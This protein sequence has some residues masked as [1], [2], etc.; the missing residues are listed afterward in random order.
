MTN[1][2]PTN[3]TRR[4]DALIED[5]IRRGATR[6]DLLKMLISSGVALGAGGSLLMKAGQAVA[7]TPKTGGHMKAAGWSSS[8]AD[9]LDP[10]KA[11]LSTDYTR[12]CALYNR[13]TFL[14]EAGEVD[15]ELAESIESSDAKTWQVKLRSGISFHDGKP[16]T[17]ADVVFSLKR[18]LDPDVGSAVNSIA[19]QMKEIEAEDDLSLRIVLVEPNADLP[20]ILSL[21]HFLIVADGT[22]DFSKGNGT[23]AFMLE[24]FEPGVRSIAVRNPNYFK[25]EGPYLDSFE[26][27]AIS[28]NN[29]RVNALLS[30][31]VHIAGSVNARSLRMMEGHANVGTLI[32]TSGNYT[33]L[34]IRLHVEPG[35]KPG[36]IEGM[37]HLINRELIQRSVF[38][39]QAEVGNDQPVSPAN[40]YHNTELKPRDFDPERAR[41]LFEKA[42]LLGQ[43]IPVVASDAANASIDIASIMQQAGAE[44]GMNFDVQRVPSDGYWA[45]YWRKAPIHFAN[46]NPRPTPDILFSLLYSSEAP[47]NE[48]QYQSKKFDNMLVEAR[49]LLD[50]SK[51][52]DI[53]WEMQ[54]MVAND[55]G[56]IIPTYI[57][58]I[59]GLAT[60]L[61]GMR[62]NPLGPMMGFAF[63]E[64]VWLDA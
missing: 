34:N 44:I 19:K 29:A 24:E 17:S 40:R 50:E 3:W 2:T 10:A 46:I 64:Y 37:K 1:K 57:S 30:G 51:R 16:F 35:D 41:A 20:T 48:S 36:F 5:A 55:A 15:M 49:G 4:D 23:G 9:T 12:C 21:H 11:T 27:F 52:T 60:N 7:D 61:K 56:T 14:N 38:R 58:N 54:E 22:T 45:N 43:T 28:D 18:H 47:W 63:P 13:L 6:R 31:D 32:S 62:S 8:T 59:D 42:G 39:G 25:N 26:F 53:Y 33:N